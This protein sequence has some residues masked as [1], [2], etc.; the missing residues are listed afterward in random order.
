MPA[1]SRL[2]DADANNL[3]DIILSHSASSFPTTWY[4]ALLT[5]AP[6]DD[7]GAGAVEVVGAGYNRVAVTADLTNFLAAVARLKSAVADIQ[8][9]TATADWAAG[10]TQVVGV[11]MYDALTVGTYR[12]YGALAAAVNV[13]PAGPR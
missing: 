13:R 8:W 3:L 6:T 7:T 1:G 2:S 11:A 12:G 9:P 5:T 10:A 4:F